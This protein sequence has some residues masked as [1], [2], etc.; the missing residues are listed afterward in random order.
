[1]NNKPITV[2][3][4]DGLDKMFGRFRL[5]KC[6]LKGTRFE[7]AN[8]VGKR[9]VLDNSAIGYGTYIDADCRF[10]NC[11]IGRYCSVAGNVHVVQGVHPSS[12]WVST[13]PAFYSKNKKSGVVYTDSDEFEEFRYADN[14]MHEAVIG[15]DVW[16]GYGSVILA[17]VKIGNGAI[18]AAGA[19]V[20]EDVPPYAIVGGVPA[21]IIKY[22]FEPNE[23]DFLQ[24]YK[25]WNKD[26]VWIRSNYKSFKNIKQFME[27]H[28]KHE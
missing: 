11:L 18:I 17:G 1:M 6:A 21:K 15:N 25:W 23:I 8:R 3:I 16:I 22:R 24:R 20:T 12:K 26:K 5:V 28:S 27:L 19:V 7:G 9:S 4:Y 10:C 14:R 13:H 2:R